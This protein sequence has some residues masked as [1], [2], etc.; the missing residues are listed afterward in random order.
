[1]FDFS[2]HIPSSILGP[3][4]SMG[5]PRSISAPVVSSGPPAS[6]AS[7]GGQSTYAF[8]DFLP[9][10]VVGPVEVMSSIMT[11]GRAPGQQGVNKP[12]TA[13]SAHASA[14]HVMP[15][16]T[17]ATRSTKCTNVSHPM[18]SASPGPTPGTMSSSVLI[19]S[20]QLVQQPAPYDFLQHI[21]ASQCMAHDRTASLVRANMEV[22]KDPQPPVADDIGPESE[23]E[24][25]EMEV[26]TACAIVYFGAVAADQDPCPP[27][28]NACR[29][30][31]QM[32]S[33]NESLAKRKALDDVLVTQIC[34]PSE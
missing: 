31:E 1:M 9:S 29:L 23:E 34:H 10:L 28:S 30:R 5:P 11:V 18:A 17:A 7:A 15:V 6:T 20:A 14:P 13:S 27:A 26:G 2:D 24:D 32:N 3:T 12:S 8:L 25:R 16:P 33:M 4:Q 19:V 22:D 21:P